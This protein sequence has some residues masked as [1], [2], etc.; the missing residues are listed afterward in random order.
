M[1]EMN[2]DRRQF[3]QGVAAVSVAGALGI[4]TAAGQTL[5]ASALPTE[6]NADSAPATNQEAD[7][8]PQVDK[9]SFRHR[10]IRPA[11]LHQGSKV[12]LVAPASGVSQWDIRDG[13]RT[14]ESLGLEVVLGSTINNV[15]EFLSISN[16]ERAADFMQF[17]ERSDI[18]GIVC[19][20][21]GYGVMRMLPYLDYDL[22]RRHPKVVVGYSDITALVNAIVARSGV[23]AFH[24]PVAYSTFDDYTTKYFRKTLFEEAAVGEIGDS[25]EFNTRRFS[26]R[27]ML[28][29]HP[30]SATGYLCGGNLTLVVSTLGT[31]Y[32]IDTRDGVLFLEDVSEEP[33]KLDRMLTQLWLAGKLQQCRALAFGRFE[34]CDRSANPYFP[35]SL[36][37]V[38][39]DWTERVG[40][41]AVYGLPVGHI[42]RKITVP[43][44]ARAELDADNLILNILDPAVSMA[45]VR[46]TIRVDV[47]PVEHLLRD[48][49]FGTR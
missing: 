34:K 40:V 25:G 10:M 37:E 15:K 38:L 43:V 6:T 45:P 17:V 31:P 32:E 24:G 33:Y 18:D 23:M 47:E 7:A 49:A 8:V 3:L 13:I 19:A 22:I 36:E 46:S 4:T 30:G 16:E 41:P 39:R 14:L 48:D 28:T 20:R 1:T 26:R 11:A 42:K 27:K 12:A 9:E 44:G 21:G 5:P 35:H 29:L 2:P